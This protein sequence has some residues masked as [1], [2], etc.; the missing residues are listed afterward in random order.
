M[1][2]VDYVEGYSLLL[3]NVQYYD[4]RPRK[5]VLDQ[6]AD[7]WRDLLLCVGDGFAF[8]VCVVLRCV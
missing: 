6:I 1:V 8:L 4:A 7:A 2:D 5:W 3:Q